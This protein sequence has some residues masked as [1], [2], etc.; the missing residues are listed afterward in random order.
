MTYQL[1]N[2][3]NA[4]VTGSY[5]G[6]G[7]EIAE[8]M[9]KNG[10][11]LFL[12]DI[13]HNIGQV[14]KEIEVK[15]GQEVYAIQADLCCEKSIQTIVKKVQEVFSTIDILV[16]NAGVMQTKP[17]LEITADDWDRVLTINLKSV[18]LLSQAIVPEMMR[19]NEG[20]IINMSSIAGRS[21]R[22]LA[23]HYAA[24]KAGIISLTKSMAEAF[25]KSNIRTNAICPGVIHTPMMEKIKADRKA[26]G[27][28]DDIE[29][30]FLKQVKLNRLGTPE[31]IAKTALY[32]ASDL[33][34][35]V[36]GQAIN[37]CGGYEMD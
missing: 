18:F 20:S 22:P 10:A 1:L 17:F 19:Q 7:R 31:D 6:I 13:N 24:S 3:K 23:P 9:A 27:D 28:S 35:Y 5:Q 15:Y 11:K 14:A 16:N 25:G 29:V 12:V 8:I 36:N 33:S 26:V 21:G 32:L 37:V 2:G 30:E 4:I 34:E